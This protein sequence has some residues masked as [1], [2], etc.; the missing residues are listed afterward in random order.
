M[1][2]GREEVLKNAPFEAKHD[3]PRQPQFLGTGYYYWD[4]NIE[5]AKIYGKRK[6]PYG[7]FVIETEMNLTFGTFLDL[8]GRRQDMEIL[9]KLKYRLAKIYKPASGWFLG[10]FIEF[11]KILQFEPG[12]EDIFPYKAVRVGEVKGETPYMNRGSL[13]QMLTLTLS[14]NKIPEYPAPSS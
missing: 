12:Y 11:L 1:Q 7:F 9:L 13:H 14:G 3:P 10:S 6:Y 2:G 5:Y 8:V 4:Y